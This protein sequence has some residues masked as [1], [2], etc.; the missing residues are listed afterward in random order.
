[1]TGR[2][3]IL[4]AILCFG[5][6]AAVAIELKPP[7]SER[8]FWPYPLHPETFRPAG[9]NDGGAAL[10]EGGGLPTAVLP[11]SGVQEFCRWGR[12]PGEVCR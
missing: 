5:V 9:E 2:I 7:P 1:M 8:F 6:P 4:A 10:A 12:M 11:S 3:L